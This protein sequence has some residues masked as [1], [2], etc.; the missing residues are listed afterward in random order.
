MQ[1]YREEIEFGNLSEM[2]SHAVICGRILEN[3]GMSAFCIRVIGH[4]RAI[5]DCFFWG[6]YVKNASP[7]SPASPAGEKRPQ[8]RDKTA[9]P[10]RERE[11]FMCH[12]C[13]THVSPKRGN[14]T[15][16]SEHAATGFK[17]GHDEASCPQLNSARQ[18]SVCGCGPL[19]AKEVRMLS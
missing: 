11:H 17:W 5:R 4:I 6:V 12:L 8:L 7:A 15:L 16:M 2:R 10:H 13:V 18:K 14:A 19:D 9:L 3:T 1:E